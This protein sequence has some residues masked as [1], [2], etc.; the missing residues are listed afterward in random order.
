MFY[1]GTAIGKIVREKACLEEKNFL[2]YKLLDKALEQ[3]PV[4]LWVALLSFNLFMYSVMDSTN[5]LL[6]SVLAGKLGK[7]IHV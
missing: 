5:W 6:L 3:H 1:S 2:H 7:R 4:C